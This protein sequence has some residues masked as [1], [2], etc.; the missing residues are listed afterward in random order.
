MVNKHDKRRKDA[1]VRTLQKAK[2]Q[3][4]TMG[5]YLSVNEKDLS[6]INAASDALEHIEIALEQLSAPVPAQ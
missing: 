6:I 4:E 5:L 2:E 3:A 1:L